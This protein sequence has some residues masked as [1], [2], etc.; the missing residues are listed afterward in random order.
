MMKDNNSNI[1]ALEKILRD[2]GYPECNIYFGEQD[3]K[4]KVTIGTGMG[5]HGIPRSAR[6][7][8]GE[9]LKKMFNFEILVFDGE[10]IR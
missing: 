4:T 8:V 7:S 9:R 5:C 10:V 6:T 3:G 2:S 1:K